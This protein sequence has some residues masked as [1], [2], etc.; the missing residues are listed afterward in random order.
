M[1]RQFWIRI[2]LLGWI[3]MFAW[4]LF[5]EMNVLLN[6]FANQLINAMN[7]IFGAIGTFAVFIGYYMLVKDD[8]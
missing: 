1:S 3:L 8:K 6:L 5:Y 7:G 4:F 2:R